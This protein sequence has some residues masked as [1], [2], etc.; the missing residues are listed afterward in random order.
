MTT[1]RTQEAPNQANKDACDT[2][3]QKWLQCRE[4]YLR[5]GF[6]HV[7]DIANCES[8]NENPLV[9]ANPRYVKDSTNL[10]LWA[11]PSTMADARDKSKE[12]VMVPHHTYA[13]LVEVIT[14]QDHFGGM[15]VEKH[16]AYS[17]SST[18][19][20]VSK[21]GNS[22]AGRIDGG[23]ESNIIPLG[24]HIR[25]DSEAYSDTESSTAITMLSG[26]MFTHYAEQLGECPA[27]ANSED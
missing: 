2:G 24:S 17:G 23:Q 14:F 3:H 26:Y 7:E 15:L 11:D 20:E 25:L 8:R 13:P 16:A 18:A 6:E 12:S 1:P 10:S 22:A 9:N 21:S 5:F 27:E 4:A 19:V